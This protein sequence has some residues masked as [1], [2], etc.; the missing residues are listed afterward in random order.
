[1]VL[2]QVKG[3][4]ICLS[5]PRLHFFKLNVFGVFVIFDPID[6]SW[7]K[8]IIVDHFDPLVSI[9]AVRFKW[10]DVSRD[11]KLAV[12]SDGDGVEGSVSFFVDLFRSDAM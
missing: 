6:A 11:V 3:N 1:M 5:E 10:N 9:G 4:S 12:R 8:D 2:F 7:F